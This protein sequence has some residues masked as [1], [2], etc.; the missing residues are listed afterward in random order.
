MSM[1]TLQGDADLQ[2]GVEAGFVGGGR[3]GCEEDG[4]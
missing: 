1:L 4:R 2:R 3:I